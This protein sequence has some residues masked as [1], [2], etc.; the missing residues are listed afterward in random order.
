MGGNGCLGCH[1]DYGE[2]FSGPMTVRKAEHAFVDATWGRH[3]SQFFAKNCDSC[4]VE[5]CSDCHGSGHALQMPTT[6]KCVRCHKGYFVGADYQGLAPRENSLRFQ[7]GSEQGGERYLQM[8]PDIHQQVGMGCSD[9]HTMKSLAQG[10]S[11]AKMCRD[12]H[13][14]SVEVVEHRQSAHMTELE[15]YACHSA[16]S[17]QEY[18]TFWLRFVD[19][20]VRSSFALKQGPNDEYLQGVYLRQQGPPPLG[21]NEQGRVSP[22]RPEFIAYFTHL[23]QD[24]VV[25]EENELL[26]RRWKAYFPHTVRRSTVLCDGCHGNRKRFMLENEEDRLY[27]LRADGLGFDSFWNRAGQEVVNGAFFPPLR[28]EKMS[29]KSSVYKKAYVERWKKLINHVE[30]SFGN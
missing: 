22:I 17:P 9:C 5:S 29:E 30:N 18:G 19:S 28:F 15:C 21:L 24:R 20:P 4:H 6:Q 1:S 25:G 13:K 27:A 8:I 2:F 12:C 23:E 11:T 7:R 10:L 26:A 3:D 14:P 16:W